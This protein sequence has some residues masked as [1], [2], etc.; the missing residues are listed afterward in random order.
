[1]L[2]MI[3]YDMKKVKATGGRWRTYRVSNAGS[4]A[5]HPSADMGRALGA[6]RGGLGPGWLANRVAGKPKTRARRGRRGRVGGKGVN[7]YA[8]LQAGRIGEGVSIGSGWDRGFGLGPE[9]TPRAKPGDTTTQRVRLCGPS[10]HLQVGVIQ[11]G[12]DWKSENPPKTLPK[13]SQNYLKSFLLV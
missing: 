6:H 1:M 13:P 12:V 9:S 2:L 7:T 3:R 5:T 4:T 8:F 10:A 11:G